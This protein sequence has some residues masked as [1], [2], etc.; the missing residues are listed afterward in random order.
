MRIRNATFLNLLVFHDPS[1]MQMQE[2]Y[3]FHVILVKCILFKLSSKDLLT[4]RSQ[5][6]IL[7]DLRSIYLFKRYLSLD[8][9]NI[10]IF[11]RTFQGSSID[12]SA[13]PLLESGWR[14]DFDGCFNESSDSY[15]SFQVS[16][17]LLIK[18][19]KVSGDL[20]KLEE[21]EGE[22]P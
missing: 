8:F 1:S 7:S 4:L 9:S 2:S 14:K 16:L 10:W 19:S 6:T 3:I 5:K 11:M 17:M 15:P 12:L 13:L 18:F 20:V 22:L 21:C